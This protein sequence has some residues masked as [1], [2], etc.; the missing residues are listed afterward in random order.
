MYTTMSLFP[1][2]TQN[3]PISQTSYDNFWGVRKFLGATVCKL[4]LTVSYLRLAS[5]DPSHGLETYLPGPQDSR[6]LEKFDP[7][8][9][10]ATSLSIE[11][12]FCTIQYTD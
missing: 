2:F 7:P 12:E 3:L 6:N 5:P 9:R 4:T 10:I 11:A 8:E 1:I